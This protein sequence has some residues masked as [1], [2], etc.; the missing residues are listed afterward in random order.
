MPGEQ[1]LATEAGFIFALETAWRAFA[2][3]ISATLPDGTVLADAALRARYPNQAM[4]AAVKAPPTL[5]EIQR[6]ADDAV[7]AVRWDIARNGY[8]DL[9]QLP[10]PPAKERP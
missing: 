5:E 4:S 3:D 10:P 7:R 8:D 9:P 6:A 2:T 1:I